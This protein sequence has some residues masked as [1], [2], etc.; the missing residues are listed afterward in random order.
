MRLSKNL[1]CVG[2]VGGGVGGGLS[3]DLKQAKSNPH[4]IPM[5]I[6][7]ATKTKNPIKIF[8]L[9]FLQHIALRIPVASFLNVIA[10]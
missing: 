10:S 9:Q 4:D 6:Y 2:G 8:N 3:F 5:I 7:I 1:N